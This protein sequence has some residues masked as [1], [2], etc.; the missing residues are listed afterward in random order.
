[1]MFPL[2][3]QQVDVTPCW[4]IVIYKHITHAVVMTFFPEWKQVWYGR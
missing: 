3:Q 4:L 1:M 2:V